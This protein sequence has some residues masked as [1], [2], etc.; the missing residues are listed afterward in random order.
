MATLRRKP[1][2]RYYIDDVIHGQR[3]R[4]ALTIPGRNGAVRDAK[5]AETLFEDY[6]R[7]GRPTILS[8]TDRVERDRDDPRI[9]DLVTYYEDEHLPAKNAADRT[10]AVI[11]NQLAKF[12]DFCAERRI[13]RVS[14]LSPRTMTEFTTWLQRE[15]KLHPNTAQHAL[16]TVRAMLNAAALAEIIPESPVKRWLVPKVED[17]ERRPLTAGEL[18]TMLALLSRA[19]A[20][21][22]RIVTHMATTGNRP[23]DAC[24][25]TRDRVDI[26]RGYISRVSVKARGL[27]EYPLTPQ[28]L[29]NIRDAASTWQPGGKLVFTRD[30]GTPWTESAIYQAFTRFMRRTK[31]PRHVTLRDLRHTFG[32]IAANEPVCVPL[33][34]LQGMLGH[35]SVTM[36]M[37]YVLPAPADAAM[38]RFSELLEGPT[39]GEKQGAKPGA[40]PLNTQAPRG[41]G[42]RKPSKKGS[43]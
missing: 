39:R 33:P 26:E 30:N 27:R 13:G 23:S 4:A 21:L 37:K 15:K 1:D 19:P 38:K 3:T 32:T 11:S 17:T 36:T 43:V 22:R 42:R 5:M 20:D 8:T 12:K 7:N 25:L 41:T 6:L 40:K 16:V 2:G 24:T 10:Y 9:R 34:V 14:Q 28:A 18:A 31:F 29:A 35:A